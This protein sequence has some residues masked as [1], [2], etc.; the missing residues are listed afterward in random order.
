ML[1]LRGAPALS[2]F[3]SRKLFSL[4]Q[5]KVPGVNHLYAEFMHFADLEDELTAP[6][7]DTLDRLLVYGP[8]VASEEPDLSLIHISEPT[9]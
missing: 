4:I 9:D 7:Q 8:S 2:P 1:E 5:E 6:E 3:R